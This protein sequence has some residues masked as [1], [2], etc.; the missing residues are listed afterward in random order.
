VPARGPESLPAPWS[1]VAS[2]PRLSTLPSTACGGTE[3]LLA[4]PGVDPAA[5]EAIR[6]ELHAISTSEAPK[7]PRD[8]DE[9]ARL[10]AT[11]TGN[12]EP[13]TV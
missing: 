13:E 8:H 1:A 12:G 6:A 9:G 4:T 7:K 11:G 5:A 2:H 10:R 3:R